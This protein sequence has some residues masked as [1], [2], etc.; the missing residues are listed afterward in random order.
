LIDEDRD[1]PDIRKSIS[2]GRRVIGHD[3]HTTLK[4]TNTTAESNDIRTDDRDESKSMEVDDSEPFRKSIDHERRVTCHH[5]HPR[6]IEK[7]Y[8]SQPTTSIIARSIN[9]DKYSYIKSVDYC[10][11]DSKEFG[12]RL[13]LRDVSPAKIPTLNENF[14]N[15]ATPYFSRPRSIE[16]HMYS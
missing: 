10:R 15:D 7:R 13:A 3:G 16:L 8:Y 4:S 12:S 9:P 6:E 11:D 2:H 1:I 5:R 14:E